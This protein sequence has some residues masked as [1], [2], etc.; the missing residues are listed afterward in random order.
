[1]ENI[2]FS[3]KSILGYMSFMVLLILA[4]LFP[5]FIG[6]VVISVLIVPITLIY[7]KVIGQSYSFVIDQSNL[8]YKMNKFG[9]NSLVVIS[10]ILAFVILIKLMFPTIDLSEFKTK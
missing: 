3:L 8:L 9:Q 5:I 4:M 7:S 6:L 2:L 1:M 10:C